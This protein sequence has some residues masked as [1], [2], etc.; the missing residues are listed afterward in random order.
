MALTGQRAGP[1]RYGEE[2]ST[3]N[4]LASPPKRLK[5][6]LLE[7]HTARLK[8]CPPE[9]PSR[10]A[11]RYFSFT[12]SNTKIAH[13]PTVTGNRTNCASRS[14]FPLGTANV[15][16]AI[17]KAVKT[18]RAN[19]VFECTVVHLSLQDRQS[20]TA[21]QQQSLRR[22]SSSE[23][24]Q[25]ATPARSTDYMSQRKKAAHRPPRSRTLRTN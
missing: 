10:I 19:L 20:C 18:P 17:A 16:S 2:D 5:P 3:A 9:L 11:S 22:A 7:P 24:T 13:T 1:A 15:S 23:S 4:L 6:A 14:V 8:S 12:K 21:E 25:I